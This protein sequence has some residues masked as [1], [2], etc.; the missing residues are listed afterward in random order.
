[1]AM[2]S[3]KA[4]A[5][6]K[7][8]LIDGPASGLR[9]S[10]LIASVENRPIIAAGTIAPKTMVTAASKFLSILFYSPFVCKWLVVARRLSLRYPW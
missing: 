5:K 4:N 9:P 3:V 7:L 6:I 8:A 10:D 2:A 1:M